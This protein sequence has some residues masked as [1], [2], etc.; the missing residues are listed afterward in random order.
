VMLVP[1]IAGV[2]GYSLL[3]YCGALVAFAVPEQVVRILF[4]LLVLCLGLNSLAP[5]FSSMLHRM[6]GAST[7]AGIQTNLKEPLMDPAMQE[8]LQEFEAEEGAVVASD[9]TILN[10]TGPTVMGNGAY[11]ELSW[12]WMLCLGGLFG[13][14]GG[15]FGIGAGLLMNAPL[16]YIFKLHKDDSRAISLALLCPPVTIGA[17]VEYA[18]NQDVKVTVAIALFFSYS[19]SNYFGAKAG[20]TMS[21]ERYHIVFG[22][23]MVCLGLL[24][25]IT[26]ILSYTGMER[27]DG[28]SGSRL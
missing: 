23:L 8:E 21:T 18:I 6:A 26:G 15:M 2:V 12:V 14:I 27:D 7:V 3:T 24:S 19:I 1:I 17:V 22:I 10:P 13:F 25:I 28:G 9:G 5:F 4:G 16:N 20:R 11:A